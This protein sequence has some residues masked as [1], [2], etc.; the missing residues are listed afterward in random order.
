M[1]PSSGADSSR[2]RDDP[3]QTRVHVITQ[4]D[5]FVP[6]RIVPPLPEP[7]SQGVGEFSGRADEPYNSILGN[8]TR[9]SQ[10]EEVA[11]L[12]AVRPGI[13]RGHIADFAPDH[14]RSLW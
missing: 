10:F 7:A 9:T 5:Q 3:K 8:P 4:P 14:H 11:L 13:A 6:M 2:R 12:L 1:T